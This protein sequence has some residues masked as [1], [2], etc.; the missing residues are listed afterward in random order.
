MTDS[1]V[2]INNRMKFAFHTP[3]RTEASSFGEIQASL[4]SATQRCG[5]MSAGLNPDGGIEATG[6]HEIG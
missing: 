5:P 2:R 4:F 1:N 6:R 3:R